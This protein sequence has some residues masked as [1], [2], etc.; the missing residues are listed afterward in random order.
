MGPFLWK[1]A[2]SSILNAQVFYSRSL[3]I[4]TQIGLGSVVIGVREGGA[5]GSLVE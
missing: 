5:S 2:G 3:Q 4:E 1:V